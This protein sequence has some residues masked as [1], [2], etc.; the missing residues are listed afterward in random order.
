MDH[1]TEARIDAL[2]TEL[3]R[4]KALLAKDGEASPPTSDRRGMMKLMAVSAVGAVTGAALLGAKPAAALDGDPVIQGDFNQPASPTIIS[5]LGNSALIANSDVGYGLECVGGQGN[6]LFNAV[7]DT[8]L[9]TGS[10][11][12]TLWV[13]GDANWWAATQTD[14]GDGR[15]RK[16]SGPD[17]AGQLH[18]LPSPVRVYD[19]RPGADPAA[20]GPKAQTAINGSRTID[21]TLNGSTVPPEANG[22]LITLTIVAPASGGFAKVWPDGVTVPATSSINF[23]PG[24]N[25]ATTTVSGCGPGAKIQVLANSVA[26]FIIDVI[27]YYQ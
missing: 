8:P 12:G 10:F 24:Q 23:D 9:G 26:D 13:D 3:G 21:T 2:E 20:V 7:L 5:T 6:A 4:L 18:I 19:S 27:G 22:V 16:L 15:W 14:P 1:R 17:T 25:I 11:A